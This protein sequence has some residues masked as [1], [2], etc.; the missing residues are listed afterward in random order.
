MTMKRVECKGVGDNDGF[1]EFN[2]GSESI[3]TPG[4]VAKRR[5]YFKKH[6][7]EAYVFLRTKNQDIPDD[8]LDFMKDASLEK[9]NSLSD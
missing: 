8:V 1:F 5:D 2:A 7:L 9:A 3:D 6:I 4:S